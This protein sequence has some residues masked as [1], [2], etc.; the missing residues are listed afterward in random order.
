MN[1]ENINDPEGIALNV[2]LKLASILE[3]GTHADSLVSRA[4][5]LPT[6]IATAGITQ[7]ITFYLSKSNL[8]ESNN[9]KCFADLVNYLLGIKGSAGSSNLKDCVSNDSTGEGKGYLTMLAITT[10]ALSM[11]LNTVK[12][13]PR[14]CRDLTTAADIASCFLKLKE[15]KSPVALITIE[16]K[17][18]DILVTIKRLA[19]AF[20]PARKEEETK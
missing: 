1:S 20:Y 9:E 10:A 5:D 18:T 19:E 13:R 6:L 17:L 12:E 7:A 14:E 16:R 11:V 15:S 4:K 3:P 2:I 8:G